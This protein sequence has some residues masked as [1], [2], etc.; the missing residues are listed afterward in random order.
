MTH[1]YFKHPR[2]AD[3]LAW[4]PVTVLMP[5]SGQSVYGAAAVVEGC[6]VEYHYWIEDEFDPDEPLGKM[7]HWQ[8]VTF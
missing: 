4:I 8:P 1:E 7:T 3:H 2:S 5:E 6:T